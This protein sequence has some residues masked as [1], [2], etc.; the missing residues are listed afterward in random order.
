M[1]KIILSFIA[2]S[3][4]ALTSC[5]SDDDNNS[6]DPVIVDPT[7]PTDPV[8]NFAKVVADIELDGVVAPDTY[9]FT[10]EGAT[11]VSYSGQTTR[12]AMADELTNN[13][14]KDESTS[15]TELNN[16]FALGTGFDDVTLTGRKIREKTG[17][18]VDFFDGNSENVQ[19]KAY[20][21]DL[22][23][24]Q[25]DNVF[26]NWS[27]TASA[28]N[29]GQITDGDDTRYINAKGI[30]NN[31]IFAKG[32]IGAMQVDQA[33]NSYMTRIETADNETTSLAAGEY[34]D[35]EHFFDEAY[36][37]LLN[38]ND[39][40]FFG[41]YLPKVAS[42]P[43][44]SEVQTEIEQAFRI[45]RQA[46]VDQKYDVR[47]QAIEVLRYQVSTVVAVRTIYYLQAGKN[48]LT[49]GNQGTAC[50]DLSEGIGF[51]YSL[52]FTRKSNV[53]ETYFSKS[54]IDGFLSDIEAGNGLWD[55]TSATLDS[56]CEDI[57]AKFDFTVAE[58]GI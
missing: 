26:T 40:S 48:A 52:R 37:Y 30:E 9:D 16:M 12:I 58:A 54:E 29:P 11:T 36:G 55:I 44:F 15:L 46:I 10:R 13:H 49:A 33:L 47:D 28:G 27:T 1:K 32:L 14:F 21:D 6:T 31:Q 19:I 25:V 50:H 45:A 42:N 39:G 56:I 34:N 22:I 2:L 35:M 3:T 8:D 7:D 18:S 57:A 5:S 4:L 38:P 51:L 43:N 17:S 23:T 53:K 20:F 24:D 41:K